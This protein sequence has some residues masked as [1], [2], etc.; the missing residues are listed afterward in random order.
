[1]VNRLEGNKVVGIKQTVKA[2]KNGKV[3]VVYVAKD[4]D[5]KLIQQIKT[6]TEHNSLQLVEVNSMKE[7]GKMCGIDVGAATSAILK[8]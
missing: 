1:M 2:I 5:D 3:K 8:D 6:L 4:A 7:L